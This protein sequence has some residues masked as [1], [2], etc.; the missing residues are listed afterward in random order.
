MAAATLVLDCGYLREPGIVTLDR[1][2][3]LQLAL[4]QQR[5]RLVLRNAGDPLL[6]LV[7]FAGLA[8]VLCVEPGWE[9]EE[10]EQP[11]GVEEEGELDDP[12]L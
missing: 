12:A 11:G 8:G 7:D 6:E 3:R 1:L 10:R 2:L 4:K 5:R 9:S